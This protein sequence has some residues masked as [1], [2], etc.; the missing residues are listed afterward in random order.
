[1][2]YTADLHIHSHYADGTSPSLNLESLY[3]WAIVK[4]I[5][6]LG[7][8]DFTHPLW[9]KE[10][11]E[12]LVQD[13]NNF[14]TLKSLPKEPALPRL[15][16]KQAN[17]HFCLSAEVNCE[18]V[19]GGRRRRVHHLIYAPSFD[20][21]LR[22]NKKLSSYGNLL[23]DGRPTIHLSSRNLLEIL[24]EISPEAYLVPAHVWTPWFSMLGSDCGYNS[25]EECFQDLSEFIFAL[26]TGLSTDPAMNRRCSSLDRFSM[27]SN[28]DAHSLQNLGREANLFNTSFSYTGMFNALKT[29]IGFTGTYEFFPEVGKYSYDGHRECKVS[30]SPAETQ[31]Y[32]GRCPSCGKALTIGA[33]N[34]VEQLADSSLTGSNDGSKY[35]VPLLQI[36]AEIYNVLPSGK[37]IQQAYI[38]AVNFFG[39]EFEL[40]HSTPIVNIQSYDRRL[41]KAIEN[42][43]KRNVHITPGYDGVYGKFIFP[44]D[45]TDKHTQLSIF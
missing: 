16:P 34:R 3:Q 31:K 39:N 35:I 4:G 44:D 41:A 25:V 21:A 8:G 29:G 23:E 14:F 10:L 43:R 2:H 33:F 1:M 19:S 42:M 5:H 22:I 13:D 12:K 15:M 32:K 20:I 26:E 27:I 17:V 36:L 7:S 45:N 6:V 30:L 38:K 18:Y 24:L 37:R 11:Q 9:M 40:L 28:S